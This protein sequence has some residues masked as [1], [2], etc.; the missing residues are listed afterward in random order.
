MKIEKHV[1]STNNVIS[2]TPVLFIVH[3][4]ACQQNKNIEVKST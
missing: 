4:F 1:L 2:S 3:C